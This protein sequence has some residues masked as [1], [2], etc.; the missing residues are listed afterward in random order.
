MKG[1]TSGVEGG[2]RIVGDRRAV[3]I[4][5]SECSTGKYYSN[6]KLTKKYDLQIN[7]K[8]YIP[9][10]ETLSI[11]ELI[12]KIIY[13]KKIQTAITEGKLYDITKSKKFVLPNILYD[14]DK[15]NLKPQ[16]QDSLKNLINTMRSFPN[17]VI[18]L[19]SHTDTRG[20]DVY[21][22]KLSFNR[23]KSVVDYLI[24]KGIDP[25]RLVAKGYGEKVPR[26]IEKP[27][28]IKSCN[29]TYT[30]APG[31]IITDDFISLLKGGKCQQEAAHQ[32][33]RRTEI[34][35]LREDFVPGKEKSNKPVNIE[36]IKK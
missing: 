8:D 26:V 14:Y 29:T 4:L 6:L 32:L 11:G 13:L 3:N 16:Y 10:V 35:V 34:K 19:G 5:K 12:N 1:G 9:Y 28:K 2:N 33:N 24:S 20:S 17:I 23:A 21:N 22:E 7:A 36:V 31:D 27:F 18:E 30:F 25:D 15:Y